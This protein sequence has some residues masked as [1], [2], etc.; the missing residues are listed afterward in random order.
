MAMVSDVDLSAYLSLPRCSARELLAVGRLLLRAIPSEPDVALARAARA[1]ERELDDFMSGLEQRRKAGGRDDASVEEDLDF[2]T[3]GL[4]KIF[5]ERLD[6]WRVFERQAFRRL[7]TKQTDKSFDYAAVV[8]RGGRATYLR[9]Y[10]FGGLGTDFTR[11]PYHI[12]V[13][14]IAT[15]WTLIDNERL[16]SDYAELVGAEMIEALRDCHR[17]YLEM[18]KARLERGDESD[19]N[20][21]ARRARLQRRLTLYIAAV[22]VMADEDDEDS[23]GQAQKSLAPIDML[24]ELHSR[25]AGTIA[26]EGDEEIEVDRLIAELDALDRALG[27]GDDSDLSESSG[28]WQES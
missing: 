4:W 7:A 16:E 8:D 23:V 27:L 9:D 15:V 5:A 26:H 1:L 10:L 11:M 18:V 3:D 28:G 2:A 20:L 19:F 24:R 25:E 12:Q 17:H 22:V 21:N 6:Q 13:E 14:L